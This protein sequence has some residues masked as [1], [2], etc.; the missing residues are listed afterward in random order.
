MV[1]FGLLPG[2]TL[3]AQAVDQLYLLNWLIDVIPILL[4]PFTELLAEK[5][6]PLQP[7][8]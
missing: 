4:R 8:K 3:V 2:L 7:Q 6:S 5:F 1:T